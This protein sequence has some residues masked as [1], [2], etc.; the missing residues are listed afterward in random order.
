MLLQDQVAV[1]DSGVTLGPG[2][3]FVPSGVRFCCLDIE[4]KPWQLREQDLA[5]ACLQK[6]LFCGGMIAIN[7]FWQLV[8]YFLGWS[9][10]PV[11]SHVQ[12]AKDQNKN[13]QC[14]ETGESRSSR[15]ECQGL[16]SQLR[17]EASTNG[18]HCCYFLQWF[19]YLRTLARTLRVFHT[20]L[21][22]LKGIVYYLWAN[23]SLGHECL[24]WVFGLWSFFFV[25][26]VY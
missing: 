15:E 4:E 16:P 14:G 3:H 8:E 13:K 25:V 2:T 12:L 10:K 19:V 22:A 20:W 5:E 24:V 17:C 6:Y 9:F 21:F 18:G 23:N 11:S 1:L 7:S 26:V